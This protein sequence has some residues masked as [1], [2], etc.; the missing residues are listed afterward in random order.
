MFR[1]QDLPLY[2]QIKHALMARIISSVYRYR[3]PG[4]HTL[5]IEFAVARGTIK[6]AIDTLVRDGV[7]VKRQGKGTFIDRETVTALHRDHPVVTLSRPH[8][9][10][11]ETRLIGKM[12]TMADHDTAKE[13][14]M[15]AG[16]PIIRLERRHFLKNTRRECEENIGYTTTYLNGVIYNGLS[17]LQGDISLY[18]QL[19]TLFG[20]CPGGIVENIGAT[21]ADRITANHLG[22]AEGSAVLHIRRTGFD[23]DERI[24]EL[25]HSY[26]VQGEIT[27]QFAIGQTD[28]DDGWWCLLK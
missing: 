14:G 15:K 8:P 5:A 6:H 26:L 4:E 18:R 27:L 21:A 12:D 28:R 10:S 20:H 7:L 19:R 11:I 22:I 2:L 23:R 9:G 3:L 1:R 25:S 13:M 24:A 16:E 17:G